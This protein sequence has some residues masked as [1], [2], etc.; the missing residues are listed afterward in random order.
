MSKAIKVD[1]VDVD[2]NTASI[3]DNKSGVEGSGGNDN[4]KLATN[5]S[6]E[7]GLLDHPHS[8]APLKL[9]DLIPYSRHPFKFYEGQ[10]LDDMVQSIRANGI[11]SLP[12]VRPL[13]FNH[14]EY[15]KGVNR[16]EILSGHNRINAAG[17][18]G[19]TETHC[20]VV[21]GLTDD[22]AHLYV[23]ESN[24]VQRS[25]ADLSHSER[26]A[27]LASHYEAMKGQGKRNDLVSEIQNLILNNDKADD[28]KENST[29]ATLRHK[30][31]GR[32][33]LGEKYGM[34][35]TMVAQYIRLDDLTDGF[36][37]LLDNDELAI[38]AAYSLSFL[39]TDQQNHLYKYIMEGG[40]DDYVEG[41][42]T[43]DYGNDH[44]ILKISMK[45]AEQIKQ[46]AVNRNFKLE[47]L[48]GIFAGKSLKP[49]KPKKIITTKFKR[50]EIAQFVG[51]NTTDEAIHALI[52]EAL[53]FHKMFSGQMQAVVAGVETLAG[54]AQAQPTHQSSINQVAV[55]RKSATTPMPSTTELALPMPETAREGWDSL[56]KEAR[57]NISASLD[58][59]FV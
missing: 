50:Q 15:V 40:G 41:V 8:V 24:L 51:E 54:Q 9:D 57:A 32:E 34:G 58:A 52:I 7:A 23:T 33:M 4:T 45:Q 22:E 39:S 53:T 1:K 55:S 17:I 47:A 13:P 59:F 12:I 56:N 21:S 38:R 11:I 10:R 14:S 25:F 20:V 16:F 36:K 5:A 44:P 28:T 46:L 2:E 3:K 26:A 27:A 48:D 19:Y 43:L 29:S 6:K 35:K 49:K 42:D 37:K 30:L 31:Q 18:V